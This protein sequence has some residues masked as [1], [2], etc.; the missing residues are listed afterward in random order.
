MLEQAV[1]YKDIRQLLVEM[2]YYSELRKT[3]GPRLLQMLTAVFEQGVKRGLVSPA[4]SGTHRPGISRGL[5]G[6]VRSAAKRGI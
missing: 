1:K 2:D 4:R 6:V 3:S 5:A